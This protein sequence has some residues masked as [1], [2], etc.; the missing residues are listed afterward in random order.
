MRFLLYRTSGRIAIEDLE[1]LDIDLNKYKV[2]LEPHISKY[3][4]E[5]VVKYAIINIKS[6]EEL[7]ELNKDYGDIV[8][9]NPDYVKGIP[10]IEIYDTYRE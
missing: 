1:Q 10:E 2:Y 4:K 5:E 7:M 3:D 8:I 9:Q 6:L